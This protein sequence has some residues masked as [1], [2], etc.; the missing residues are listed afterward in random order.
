MFHDDVYPKNA[1][2][3]PSAFANAFAL[4]VAI[5]NIKPDTVTYAAA[6]DPQFARKSTAAK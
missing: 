6:I 1:M 2:V 5:G 4:Q 3:E